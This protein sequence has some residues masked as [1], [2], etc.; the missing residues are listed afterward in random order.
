[1]AGMGD[2]PHGDFK[3]GFMVGFQAAEGTD[4]EIPATPA[5][6]VTPVNMTPF[7]MGVRKGLEEAGMGFG[8]GLPP[9]R[10]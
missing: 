5:K 4:R 8:I 1:M 2:V 3:A 9:R 10:L 6:P 7:L